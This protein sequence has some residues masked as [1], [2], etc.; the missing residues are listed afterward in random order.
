DAAQGFA[1]PGSRVQVEMGVIWLSRANC[2]RSPP[3][4]CLTATYPYCV[5]RSREIP[6]ENK[7]TGGSLCTRT[8]D[9]MAYCPQ[10]LASLHGTKDLRAERECSRCIILRQRWQP[11]LRQQRDVDHK[12]YV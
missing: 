5:Y 8:S 7:G 12:L 4:R 1:L 11:G 9:E 6:Q 10:R 3:S 2:G